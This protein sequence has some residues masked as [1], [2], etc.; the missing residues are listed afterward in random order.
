[1]LD[2][3]K[4]ILEKETLSELD[5]IKINSIIFT[6]NKSIEQF[7]SKLKAYHKTTILEILQYQKN[8][9][10]N[11][12]QLAD[13]FKLSRNTITKWKKIYII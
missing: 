12:N 2:R 6:G 13:H 8:N 1:M 9:N 11:N 4:K 7:N 10:L 5:V 3:C